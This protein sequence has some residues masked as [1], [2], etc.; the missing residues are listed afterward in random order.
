[1]LDLR[2]VRYFV[3]IVDSGSMSAASR[4][5]HIAQPALSHHMAELERLVGFALLDRL[6]RGVRPTE[7]GAL[8]YAHAQRIVRE[9][10]EAERVMREQRGEAM[11]P[12]AV[13]LALIPSW[14]SI[15]T[16]AIVRAVHENLPGVTLNILEARNDEA[17]RM[18]EAGEV[19]LA[20]TLEP[21]NEPARELILQEALYALSGTSGPEQINFSELAHAKLL[22]PSR[23]NPLRVTIDDAALQAGV[24]LQ[25]GMEIEGQDT[26]KRAVEAGIG[27]SILSWNAVRNECAKG[28][29]FVSRIVAPEIHRAV[30]LRRSAEAD[31]ALFDFFRDMLRDVTAGHAG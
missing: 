5:L 12:R 17:V 8:L 25:V 31:D 11:A 20:V 21:G 13:R 18:V 7:R 27:M 4:K 23:S 15:F 22:L 3:S 24:T 16:P 14:A 1:M 29:L 19:D 2:R 9:V 10:E 6:P 26:I 30:F 28:S